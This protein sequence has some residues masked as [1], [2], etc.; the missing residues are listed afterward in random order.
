M[1]HTSTNPRAA[2]LKP[3]I[4]ILN[5]F[6]D[7]GIHGELR[8]YFGKEVEVIKKCKSGLYYVR[9]EHDGYWSIAKS[10]L[11]TPEQYAERLARPCVPF[12][13]T[14]WKVEA[15]QDIEAHHGLDLEREIAKA[16]YKEI[17]K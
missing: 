3:G 11:E 5:G 15:A 9:T 16:L 4:Y 13:P 17:L 10:N 7:L 6:G 8:K 1:S 2:D 12:D 14:K